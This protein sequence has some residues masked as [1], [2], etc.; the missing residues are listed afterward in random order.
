MPGAPG[1]KVSD[2]NR[3]PCRG[4]VL[5]PGQ[6]WVGTTQGQWSLCRGAGLAWAGVLGM[7]SGAVWPLEVTAA[8]EETMN[9][10][11]SPSLPGVWPRGRG[12]GSSR[13]G[14]PPCPGT[15]PCKAPGALQ[16]GSGDQEIHRGPLPEPAPTGGEGPCPPRPHFRLALAL[17]QEPWLGWLL[18]RR[19]GLS[20]T[21]SVT[22]R[23]LGQALSPLASVSSSDL[24]V[25]G[26]PRRRALCE[27]P[28][29][30]H[31]TFLTGS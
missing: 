20:P 23:A 18:G 16:L 26:P 8:V 11:R 31:T 5:R 22:P 15:R 19:L 3:T 29:C 12:L 9:P 14:Q 13:L 27:A 2:D 1:L 28:T 24:Q 4:L 25:L 30:L 17:A 6:Q 10:G 7:G 21:P